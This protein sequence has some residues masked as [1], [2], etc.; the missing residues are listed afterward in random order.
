MAVGVLLWK[1]S[2]CLAYLPGN[3]GLPIS[4]TNRVLKA[5]QTLPVHFCCPTLP[6]IPFLSLLSPP[7]PLSPAMA[8]IQAIGQLLDTSLVP[9]HNKDGAGPCVKLGLPNADSIPLAK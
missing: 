7:P 6:S 2:F 5:A 4:A 3:Y 1:P 8:N 9:Q